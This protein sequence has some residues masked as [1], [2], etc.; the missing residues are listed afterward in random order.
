ME[1]FLQVWGWDVS[2]GSAVGAG[3]GVDLWRMVIVE[4]E[5]YG[6]LVLY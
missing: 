4:F 5:D 1:K 6:A 2:G 3:G